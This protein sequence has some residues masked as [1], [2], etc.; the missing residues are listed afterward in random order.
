M[1]APKI[2]ASFV[3]KEEDLKYTKHPIE[4]LPVDIT[5][6]RKG[7]T[8]IDYITTYDSKKPGP[9]VMINAVVHG[10]ELCGA[11][12]LDFLFQKKIRPQHGKLTLSFANYQA[13]LS[14]DPEKPFASRYLEENFNRIWELAVLEG[15][16]TNLEI[17]RAREMRPLVETVDYLFDIHSMQHKT[18]PLMMAGMCLKG[19]QLA[20]AV[21][22][23]QHVVL[24]FGHSSGTRLRE[25]GEF[26]NP[27]SHKNALLVECGQHWAQS[28]VTLAIESTLR[29][30]LH[31][32]MIDPDFVSEHLGQVPILPQKFIEVT[33]S[34]TIQT[35]EFRFLDEFKGME[36]IS[37]KGTVLGYD[38]ELPI[39]TP[40]DDCVLIMPGRRFNPGFTA[41]RLGKFI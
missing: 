12:A 10:N 7:N 14:F 39:E 28:T 11:I 37:K 27:H 32:G 6:Y 13:Y 24:D 5:P 31:F 22:I 18:Q 16:R 1:G 17:E 35:R 23:P 25:Y 20:E 15:T 9:H 36:M 33:H 2:V 8:G 41:V 26:A 21:E 19:R 29:F 34:I 3:A 4:I 30:L 38:G 40:Y